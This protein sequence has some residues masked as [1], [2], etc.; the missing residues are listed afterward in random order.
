MT[1][2]ARKARAAYLG[3]HVLVRFIVAHDRLIQLQELIETP[4][5][6]RSIVV[7]PSRTITRKEAVLGNVS[8]TAQVQ[9]QGR[10]SELSI[11]QYMAWFM[12]VELKGVLPVA[13]IRRSD[14]GIVGI[15]R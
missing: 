15:H 10:F 4:L 14:L 5:E 1:S 2:K 8:R 9:H 11:H 3:K 6:D 7:R 13:Q 12:D